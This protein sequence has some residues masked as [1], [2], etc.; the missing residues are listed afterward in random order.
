MLVLLEI[1]N[2][3]KF[4][5][6]H[7]PSQ[8]Y[9][10]DPLDTILY[11]AYTPIMMMI[12]QQSR[13]SASP[14]GPALHHSGEE[15]SMRIETMYSGLAGQLTTE[16][17]ASSHNKPVLVVEGAAYGPAD[18]LPRWPKM[19]MTAAEYVYKW[20][21]TAGRDERDAAHAFCKQ[22]PDG[23]QVLIEA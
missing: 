22:W 9:F 13:A 10:H 3:D 21:M 6:H 19:P 1:L 11:A 18:V 15:I 20:A 2:R 5:G 14:T 16:H 17:A 8:N 23:P 12:D 4:L 7:T